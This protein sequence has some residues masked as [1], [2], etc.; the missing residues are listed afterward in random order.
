MGCSIWRIGMPELAIGV[1]SL[2]NRVLLEAGTSHGI[3]GKGCSS[4]D[5]VCWWLH[6]FNFLEH[7]KCSFHTL[8]FVQWLLQAFKPFLD[9]ENS[10]TDTHLDVG[11]MV[12]QGAERFCHVGIGIGFERFGALFC[13]SHY[14]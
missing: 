12:F 10:A 2:W 14:F 13:L 6:L 1:A 11:E 9:V 5:R 4:R 3:G 7:G 8:F